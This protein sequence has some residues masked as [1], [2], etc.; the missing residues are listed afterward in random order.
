[1]GRAASSGPRSPPRS[2]PPNWKA[3]RCRWKRVLRGGAS[4]AGSN[5]AQNRGA[6]VL[7]V[8]DAGERHGHVELLLHHLERL[9]HAGLDPRA[10][11]VDESAADHG[12]LGAAR[13]RLEKA[14]PAA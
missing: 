11:A 14:L 1:M 6:R 2:S 10:Q 8:A 12:R 13:E 7:D 4:P 3:S 9:Q 5:A